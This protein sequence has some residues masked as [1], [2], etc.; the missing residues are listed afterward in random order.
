MAA[1]HIQANPSKKV[2]AIR[3]THRRPIVRFRRTAIVNLVSCV[4]CPCRDGS[5]ILS[6]VVPIFAPLSSVRV[7]TLAGL[8][9]YGQSNITEDKDN[10]RHWDVFRTDR[11]SFPTKRNDDDG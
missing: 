3:S 11:A 10:H 5:R 9:I 1:I 2:M 8:V 6:C 7:C 4:V